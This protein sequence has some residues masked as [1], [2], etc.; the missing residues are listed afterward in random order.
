MPNKNNASS[1]LVIFYI[2]NT[3][4]Y[5]IFK[6]E[7]NSLSLKPVSKTFDKIENKPVKYV[8]QPRKADKK[9]CSYCHRCE[10]T[11]RQVH[12][13]SLCNDCFNIS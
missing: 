4:Y 1:G 11:M 13:T 7:C 6:L 3:D 5:Y 10:K 8:I 12:M 2:V 9:V